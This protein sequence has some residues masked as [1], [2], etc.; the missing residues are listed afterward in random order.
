[1]NA[2]VQRSAKRIARGFHNALLASLCAS[3][4]ALQ[5]G[6]AR[7]ASAAAESILGSWLVED[8]EAVV[9]IY[10][11]ATAFCGRI[12][13]LKEPRFPADDDGGMAGQPKTDRNN[14]IAVRRTDPI[15]GST[16]LRNLRFTG[17]SWDH[18]QLYDPETGNSYTCRARLAGA[19][20]LEIRGYLGFSLLGRTAVWT[21]LTRNG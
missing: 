7:A 3:L 1:V 19:N 11:C 6:A 4:L 17:N 15:L 5:T 14:P 2:P 10:P 8:E 18:G 12:T 13:W 21:R 16:V 20:R 9:E